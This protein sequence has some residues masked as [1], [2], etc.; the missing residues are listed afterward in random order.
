M[1][2]FQTLDANATI[3]YMPFI[4]NHAS[5]G[6][7]GHISEF[8][9]ENGRLTDYYSFSFKDIKISILFCLKLHHLN[10]I[11][12]NILLIFHQN[13]FLSENLLFIYETKRD[14][15]RLIVVIKVMIFTDSF[16]YLCRSSTRN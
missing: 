10:I 12:L 11:I 3:K 16:G 2:L 13:I 5:I 1:L 14:Y 15:Y 8:Q 4:L 9:F 6:L 7:I